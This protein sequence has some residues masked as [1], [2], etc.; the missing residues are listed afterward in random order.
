MIFENLQVWYFCIGG[1]MFLKIFRDFVVF[2]QFAVS[3]F[4][5]LTTGFFKGFYSAISALDLRLKTRLVARAF[6]LTYF[7]LYLSAEP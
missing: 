3:N 7:R 4:G 5:W 1:V 2:L 6:H